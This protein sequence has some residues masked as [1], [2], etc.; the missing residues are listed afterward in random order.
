ML[1]L[2]IAWSQNSF[3]FENFLSN[4]EK[5]LSD[6]T[7]CNSL[8]TI[9]LGDFNVRSSVWWT[10]DKT[11]MEGTQ[12]ESLTTVH[13]FDELISQPTHLLPQTS[14]CIDVIFT[15]QPNLTEQSRTDVLKY[16]YFPY[17][18]IEWNKLDM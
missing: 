1:V 2:Y 5:F 17:T 18:I 3:E 4:F 15:D 16:S 14:S 9:I 8:F 13:S 6:T 11:T 10:R 7:F 12:F